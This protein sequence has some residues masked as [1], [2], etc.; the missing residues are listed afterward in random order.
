MVGKEARMEG[1]KEKAA[2]LRICLGGI[3]SGL[4]SSAVDRVTSGAMDGL[5][6]CSSYESRRS[7]RSFLM[8]AE[9]VGRVFAIDEDKAE[10]TMKFD[11]PVGVGLGDE[12]EIMTH[13]WDIPVIFKM[14]VKKGFAYEDMN[15]VRDVIQSPLRAMVSYD[16]VWFMAAYDANQCCDMNEAYWLEPRIRDLL[17]DL[18]NRGGQ[19]IPEIVPPCVI[20]ADISLEIGSIVGEGQGV[21]FPRYDRTEIRYYG[22]EA[23]RV[24]LQQ[25]HLLIKYESNKVEVVDDDVGMMMAEIHSNIG[26]SMRSYYLLAALSHWH[27]KRKGEMVEGYRRICGAVEEYLKISNWNLVKKSMLSN[28]LGKETTRLQMRLVDSTLWDNR[29]IRR[30]AEIDSYQTDKM[31][32]IDHIRGYTKAS[33]C[34]PYEDSREEYEAFMSVVSKIDK[35]TSQHNFVLLSI[36][37]VLAGLIGAVIGS[38]VS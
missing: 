5:D 34:E 28:K 9:N 10:G 15:G 13:C 27:R 11:G 35:I 8:S 30:S 16:G 32:I 18:M 38:L 25:S 22:A 12:G 19:F 20:P 24:G 37:A 7:F 26:E 23:G 36:I 31:R 21:S 3:V 33:I 2:V 14:E 6:S 1:E 29:I 4:T 17:V